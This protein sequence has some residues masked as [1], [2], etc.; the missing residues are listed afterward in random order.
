MPGIVSGSGQLEILMD[1]AST[2]AQAYTTPGMSGLGLHGHV[3]WWLPGIGLL[4]YGRWLLLIGLVSRVS[5]QLTSG[6]GQGVQGPGLFTIRQ[7]L[8]DRYKYRL[9]NL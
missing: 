5:R 9:C 1:D 8:D 4:W 6:T 2:A 3:G 7:H